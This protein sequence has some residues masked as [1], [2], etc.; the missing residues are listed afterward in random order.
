MLS[1][2]IV[3]E[4]LLIERASDSRIKRERAEIMRKDL[5]AWIESHGILK[6]TPLQS[7]VWEALLASISTP[8]SIIRMQ[9]S[10]VIK[11]QGLTPPESSSDLS[12][13]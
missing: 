2:K 5:A 13:S 8:F 3:K 4:A 7:E 9:A 6:S 11:S 12:A 10:D 1:Q